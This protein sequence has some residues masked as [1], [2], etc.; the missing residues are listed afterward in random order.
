MTH[1]QT[2]HI[3]DCVIGVIAIFGIA[4]IVAGLVFGIL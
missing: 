1:N 3:I 2:K 4:F